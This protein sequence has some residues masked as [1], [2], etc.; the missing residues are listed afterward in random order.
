[1]EWIS[2]KERQPS[3]YDEVLIY[4]SWYEES[5]GCSGHAITNA[6][7]TL[8][9]WY[10]VDSKTRKYDDLLPN[11]HFHKKRGSDFEVLYWNELPEA[12]KVEEDCEGQ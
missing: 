6:H 11:W 9:N 4:Y 7:F 5:S 3:H 12:P 2:V 1:M 8:G 10:F